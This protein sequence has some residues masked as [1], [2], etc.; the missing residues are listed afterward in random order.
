MLVVGYTTPLTAGATSPSFVPVF[1]GTVDSDP[2]LEDGPYEFLVWTPDS[3]VYLAYQEYPTAADLAAGP[4]FA[5]F[6]MQPNETYKF[7][8]LGSAGMASPIL[9]ATTNADGAVITGLVVPKP[10]VNP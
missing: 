1:P 4:P 7:S 8:L 9:A 3:C 10:V 6:Q 5:A 2:L